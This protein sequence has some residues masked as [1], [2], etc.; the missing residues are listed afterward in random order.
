MGITAI[1]RCLITIVVAKHLWIHDHFFFSLQSSNSLPEKNKNPVKSLTD[2]NT[3]AKPSHRGVKILVEMNWVILL[4][5][6]I[7]PLNHNAECPDEGIR[8][9]TGPQRWKQK[10]ESAK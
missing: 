5:I 6:E 7:K 4:G 3:D 10:S 9:I 8:L 2:G 1:L